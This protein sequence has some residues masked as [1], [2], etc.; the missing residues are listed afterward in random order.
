MNIEIPLGRRDRL[1]RFCELVP[2]AISGLAIL[3]LLI[4]PFISPTLAVAFVLGIA[5]LVFFRSVRGAIDLL[6]GYLRYRAASRVDYSARLV[7]LALARQRLPVPASPPLSFEYDRHRS[8][9]EA[10]RKDPSLIPDPQSVRHAVIIAAYN[11]PF[12]VVQASLRSLVQSSI[13]A[14]HL[15]VFFAYEQRGGAAIRET[16]RRVEEVFGR[17]FGYFELVEHPADLPEE[18]AGKGANIT[19]AGAHVSAWAENAG[20]NPRMVLVTTLDCD[21][22]VH[23]SYFD[24]VSYEFVLADK[25]GR[26]SF[27]PVSLYTNN[28]W[29]APAPTRVIASANSFWNLTSSVRPL[30]LRN[31]ASH[32]QPLDALESMGYWSKRTIVEDGHQYWR[33]YLHFDGDY[34]VTSI[35]VP[36]FQDAVIAGSLKDTLKAQFS[37]L[38]RW[39]YGASD[40]PYVAANLIRHRGRLPVIDSWLRLFILLEGHISLAVVSLIIA[41]GGWVP[42]IVLTSAASAGFDASPIP[43]LVDRLPFIVG[44]LQQV[45]MICLIVAIVVHFRLLP[46]RPVHCPPSR[47]WGMY[48]QWFLYP[49]SML[50]FNSSTALHSQALLLLGRYREKFAVTQKAR[51]EFR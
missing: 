46:P 17:S 40:V 15:A 38:S 8:M 18:I 30:A 2:G 39:S 49:F 47:T 14:D 35:H 51:A 1:Y 20:L 31:F 7:D 34:S 22:R 24:A 41:V 23:E 19:F 5:G 42:F 26:T 43:A 50:V 11:E 16:V 25:P 36:V 44:G 45:G 37:Q 32:S 4:L 48:L 29:D 33:S 12:E 6:R 10:I 9:I 28:I 3:L 27:Q 21:N 13:P